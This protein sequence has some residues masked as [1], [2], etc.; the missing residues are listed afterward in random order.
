M[1]R[2]KM[3]PYRHA[4]G[5]HGSPDPVDPFNLREDQLDFGPLNTSRSEQN[6]DTPQQDVHT[7]PEDPTA[8]ATPPTPSEDETARL[9]AAVEEVRM[10]SAAEMENFK[11]R[12]KREHDEQ[13]RYASERVLGDLLPT[14]DNLDLALRYGSK[15]EACGDMLHGVDM[16]RK[17][18]LEAVAGHGLLP[19]GK[20]G[21]PFTPELFEAV[22]VEKRENLP[23]G[24]VSR[25]LQ[26]GYKLGDRLLR[27]AK[28]MINQ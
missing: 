16:T 25:V 10:R 7:S 14:L 15:N 5:E 12:L 2:H 13:M 22:G 19:F 18:L 23:D 24:A 20:E 1:H 17:L 11:K 8:P 26:A 6:Q 3:D 27:P 28:V 9:K 21:E 4:Q